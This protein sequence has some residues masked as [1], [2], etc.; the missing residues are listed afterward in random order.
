MAEFGCLAFSSTKEKCTGSA[1]KR[2]GLEDCV[3]MSFLVPFI[4][5]PLD[6][7]VATE[8]CQSWQYKVLT[9]SR[10]CQHCRPAL[11]GKSGQILLLTF[12][13]QVLETLKEKE[14]KEEK[15]RFDV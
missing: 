6:P 3:P 14:E 12:N 2:I 11:K 4:M 10:C 9:M 8:L 7:L 1:S 5:P 15:G 13:I